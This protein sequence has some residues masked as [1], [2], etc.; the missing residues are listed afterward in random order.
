MT[1]ENTGFSKDSLAKVTHSQ[2]LYDGLINSSSLEVNADSSM[3]ELVSVGLPVRNGGKELR[4]AIESILCQDH[5]NIEI[6]ISD[7]CSC[8]NTAA[9]AFEYQL[10]D[11]RIIYHR[12]SKF[13]PVAEN[14]RFVLE[15]ARGNYFIWAAHDDRRS[16]DFISKLLHAMEIDSEPILTFGDCYSTSSKED[17]GHI[18]PLD[19]D[20]TS[21]SSVE[22]VQKAVNPA[23]MHLYGLWKTNVLRSIRFY[24]CIW[25]WDQPLM[26]AAAYLGKF[27]YVPGPKLIYFAVQKSH[28]ERA[29]YQDGQLGFNKYSGLLGLILS[30]Y[31]TCAGVGGWTIGII[32]ALSVIQMHSRNL[33]GFIIRQFRKIKL[34]RV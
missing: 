9:I 20:N 26:P 22:R 32:A 15:E 28:V 25:A 5:K 8:D 27:K 3:G 4:S 12:Q 31:K 34:I 6:I 18:A 19:F 24:P 23:C 16:G 10:S 13:I 14:F 21:L 7:N 11:P 29:A 1:S 17:E 30:T 33:P 2:S